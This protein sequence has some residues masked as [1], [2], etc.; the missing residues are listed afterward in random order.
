MSKFDKL[1]EY[2]KQKKLPEITLTLEEIRQLANI[3]IDHSFLQYKK[4]LADYGYEVRKISM[5]QQTVTFKKLRES[6]RLIL[7]VHGKGGTAEEAEDYRS[8]FPGCDVIGLDYTAQTPWDAE[9]E[10][11]LMTKPLLTAYGEMTLIANSIGAY[12]SMCAL[13]QYKIRKAYFISPI[14]DMEKLICNMMQWAKV[15]EKELCHKKD[16]ATEFGESLSWEYLCYARSRPPIW[17]VPTEILYG[18]LDD[19][20]DR[21]SICAFANACHAGLTVMDGGEH[22]FHTAEQ[23]E[24]LHDWIR[25][26]ENE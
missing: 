3:P 14:V 17:K 20:T 19:L 13:P 21:N 6:K 2:I 23:K 11:P 5:K 25:G 4:E 8:L 18:E 22:W 9:R 7:Y 24:F 1:W 26:R 15:S 16:I 12:F 10:F